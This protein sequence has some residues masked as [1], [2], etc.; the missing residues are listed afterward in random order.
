MK[1]YC[2]RGPLFLAAALLALA[3]C[4]PMPVH[5]DPLSVNGRDGAGVTPT[6]PALMRIAAA[7]RAGGD[8]SNAVALYRRAAQLAPSDPA[9]FVALGDTLLHMGRKNEAILAYNSALARNPRALGARSGLARAYLLTGRPELAFAPLS[10]AYG[11]H[12]KDPQLFLLLG[13]ANDETGHYSVA[14]SWYRGGL[15]IV[16]GAPNLTIDLALSLALKG[17][18]HAAIAALKPLATRPDSSPAERQTLSLIYG[19]AGNDVEA[20]RLGRRDLD[21]AAVKHNLAYF[22][23]LRRLSPKARDSA[24]LALRRAS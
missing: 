16:P 24:L 9:P 5:L 20:A 4:T 2:F 13:L 19:L 18:Y 17:D 22:A 21:D 14:E 3:G 12:P 23:S 8:L 10:S 6:Y 11:E 7:A 1:H 15:A